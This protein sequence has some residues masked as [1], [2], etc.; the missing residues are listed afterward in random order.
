[1]HFIFI[2]FTNECLSFRH[3]LFDLLKTSEVMYES[4]P[5]SLMDKSET[6]TKKVFQSFKKNQVPLDSSALPK[7]KDNTEM[8]TLA[9]NEDLDIPQANQIPSILLHSNK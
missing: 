9:T 5:P 4:T 2:G 1:M 3:H 7:D 6:F 8:S